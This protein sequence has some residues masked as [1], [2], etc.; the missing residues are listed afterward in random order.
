VLSFLHSVLNFC[1]IYFPASV[2]SFLH[3]VLTFSAIYFPASVLSFLH[4]VFTFPQACFL[5]CTMCLLS[6]NL[7]FLQV[8]LFY[9]KSVV[10]Y[11]FYASFISFMPMCFSFAKCVC[12]SF[13]C[14]YFHTHVS[15]ISFLQSYFILCFD[16]FPVNVIYFMEAWCVWFA[17][18]FFKYVFHLSGSCD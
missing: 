1:A 16:F 6:R 4:N 8:C 7:V 11:F 15:L 13:Q 14:V 17:Q 9:C 3:N 2:L 12:F 5:S 18:I 10:F